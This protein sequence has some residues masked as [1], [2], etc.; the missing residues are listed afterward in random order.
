MIKFYL[1]IFITIVLFSFQ[2]STSDKEIEVMNFD[3]LKPFLEKKNDSLYLV[4]FWATWCAPCRMELPAIEKAGKKYSKKKF[5]IL[6]VSLDMP[7]EIQS[8]L[9]PFIRKNSIRS[10]VVLLDDPDQNRWINMVSKDWSGDIPFTVIYGKK[11]RQYFNRPLQYEFLD[12]LLNSKL[13]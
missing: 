13:R 11:F 10:E 2:S 7:E 12:S 9:Y 4:N 5:K 3:K 1:L 6:L 8:R